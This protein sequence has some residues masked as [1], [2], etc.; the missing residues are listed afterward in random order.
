[1]CELYSSRNSW[2]N[3]QHPHSSQVDCSNVLRHIYHQ[4][5]ESILDMHDYSDP[6]AERMSC[7]PLMC[8]HCNATQATQDQSCHSTGSHHN[9]MLDLLFH[10]PAI[11]WRLPLFGTYH[12]IVNMKHKHATKTIMATSLP[13]FKLKCDDP[14]LLLGGVGGNC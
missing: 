2:M 10:A 4:D 1:M 14:A 9:C 13:C 3:Q 6:M 7:I 8:T 5:P 11:L 12:H